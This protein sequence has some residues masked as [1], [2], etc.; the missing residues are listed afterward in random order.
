MMILQLSGVSKLLKIRKEIEYLTD[1]PSF[2]N[3]LKVG[4]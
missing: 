3:M 2:L 4:S 1:D